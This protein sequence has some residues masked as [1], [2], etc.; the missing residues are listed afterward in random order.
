MSVVVV[1]WL[2]RGG[3]AQ[4]AEVWCSVLR[5]GGVRTSLLSRG[6]REVSPDVAVSSPLN[7]RIA[8]HVEVVRSAVRYIRET[9]P[10]TVVIQSWLLPIVELPVYIAAESVG[11]KIILAAHNH[12]SHTRSTGIDIGLGG[13][14]RRADVIVTHSQFVRNQ[15]HDSLRTRSVVLPLPMPVGLLDSHRSAV[16]HDSGSTSLNCLQ[17]GVKRE[18]KDSSLITDLAGRVDDR[19]QFAVAGTMADGI[20]PA[21]NLTRYPG[22][23]SPDQL[24]QLVARSEAVVLPYSHASQSAAVVLARCLGSIPIASA[25]GGIPEQIDHQIDGVLV[26]PKAPL[27]EWLDA[28]DLVADDRWRQ[29]V[30]TIGLSRME[31]EHN[32]FAAGARHLVGMPGSAGAEPSTAGTHP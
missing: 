5:A 24:T 18:T 28:L 8:Q 11:A 14:L 20:Q 1:D 3:I 13:I 19:W 17:F 16:A 4:V 7:L 15:L 25:V 12:R 31:A 26:S 6:G 21:P 9:Q 30:K 22:F 29:E 2:G 23:Q 10:T 27:A 32:E